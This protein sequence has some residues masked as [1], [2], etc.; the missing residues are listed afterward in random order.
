VAEA[1]RPERNPVAETAVGAAGT[2]PTGAAPA[3]GAAVPSSDPA[4]APDGASHPGDAPASGPSPVDGVEPATVAEA[5]TLRPAPE[6]PAPAS[7][8]DRGPPRLVVVAR[9]D[10]SVASIVESVLEG[11]L[12]EADFTVLDE[13]FFADGLD[14]GLAQV[15]DAALRNGADVLVYA[16]VRETGTRELRFY[17]RTEQQRTANVEV[18]ALL[19]AEKRTLGAPWS[20]PLE[21]VPL[22]A[23]DN[24]REVAGP[25]ARDLVARL[26]ALAD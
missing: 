24:A 26:G 5:P 17:G 8:A 16:D 18:R 2:T 21:Y 23:T 10:P 1:P 6:S 15:G 14:G 3:P 13:R 25:I 22:N 4:S 9:G 7:A 11:A 19:L 20:R 12:A